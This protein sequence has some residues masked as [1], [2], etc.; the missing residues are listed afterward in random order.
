MKKLRQNKLLLIVGIGFI[1][2]SCQDSNHSNATRQ[3]T[4]GVQSRFDSSLLQGAWWSDVNPNSALFLVSEDSL[5]YTDDL[6][7]PLFVKISFDSL[8]FKKDNMTS[9]FLLEK[10]TKDSLVFYDKSNNE[11]NRFSKK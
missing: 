11:Y 8:I 6:T 7:S 10:L 1:F 2:A 3:L 5:Y 9:V 4:D